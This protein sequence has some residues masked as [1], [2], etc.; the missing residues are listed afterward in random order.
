MHRLIVL[1]WRGSLGIALTWLC[2]SSIGPGRGAQVD[3]A[4]VAS[5]ATD[6][7]IVLNFRDTDILQLVTLMSDL[8][9]K[10]FLVDSNLRGTVTLV[11]P[12]PVNL[13]EAYQIFLSILKSRGF[14]TVL[15]GPIIKIIPVQKAKESPLPF[16]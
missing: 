5:P 4:A 6:R 10:T 14:T 8:T 3:P 12:S 7:Q 16:N 13:D 15:Q 11:A 1:L 2:L 9:G